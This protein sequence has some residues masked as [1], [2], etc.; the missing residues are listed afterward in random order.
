MMK[1]SNAQSGEGDGDTTVA[2][3]KS[4]LKRRVGTFN[5]KGEP[6]FRRV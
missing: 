5:Q 6:P 3:V 2:L 1:K 4:L